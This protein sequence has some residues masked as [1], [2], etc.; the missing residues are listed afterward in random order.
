MREAS[1]QILTDWVHEIEFFGRYPESAEKWGFMILVSTRFLIIIC[2]YSLSKWS[3]N[4]IF[5]LNFA[6]PKPRLIRVSA[7]T[8]SI[9]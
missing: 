8:P 6:N 5:P 9:H 3:W 2:I 7:P 4:C 1:N